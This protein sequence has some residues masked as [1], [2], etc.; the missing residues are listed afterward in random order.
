MVLYLCGPFMTNIKGPHL[1]NRHSFV[2]FITV[3]SSTVAICTR[4]LVS[5]DFFSE[6]DICII[7][8]RCIKYCSERSQLL[9][10]QLAS[11]LFH[12][13]LSFQNRSSLKSIYSRTAGPISA[14]ILSKIYG[15]PRITFAVKIGPAGQILAAKTG[16]PLPILV[17]L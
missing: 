15:C 9:L 2:K 12:A 16:P 7:K 5:Y 17:Y 4:E 1:T 14:E 8:S 10:I 3:D 11:Y 13:G 6:R